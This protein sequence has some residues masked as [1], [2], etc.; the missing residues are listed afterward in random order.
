M[1]KGGW[2]VRVD[3]Q[4][5]AMPQ[6]RALPLLPDLQSDEAVRV[7]S[8]VKRIQDMIARNEAR[9][10][11]WPHVITFEDERAVSESILEKRYP[12]EFEPPQQP[13]NFSP[14]K[15]TIDPEEAS[16]FPN[17]FETRNMGTTLEVE[18][19]AVF[20]NGKRI[21][22]SVV[23]QRVT[24]LDMETFAIGVTKDGA[25]VRIDQP[26]FTSERTTTALVVRN[27]EH[28]LLAVHQ[29][30]TPENEIEFF[31]LHAAASRTD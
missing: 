5:V 15:G 24:L 25:T 18:S 10:T 22:L 21:G 27:R 19:I 26:Q 2:N 4:M 31:I 20:D 14:P 1:E 8:A 17:T 23:P 11:G 7:E 29:L 3:V 9:L 12:T 13:Q 28:V 30:H 16:L 6:A